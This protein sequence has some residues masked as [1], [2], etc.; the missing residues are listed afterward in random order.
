MS[1]PL[2]DRI[3]LQVLVRPVPLGLLR[4][5]APSETSAQMRARVVAARERQARRLAPFGIRCNAEMSST[6]MRRT[7]RLDS[8]AEDKLFDLVYRD[9]TYTARSVDRLI[10]C[11][12]TVADLDAST[13]ITAD[14]LSEAASFR[15]VDPTA[16]LVS[17]VA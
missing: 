4:D 7:C 2:L 1:G 8:T 11:A 6:V 10:K 9:G 17:A 5:D 12:R 16:D 15:H 14:H 13:P 3:D